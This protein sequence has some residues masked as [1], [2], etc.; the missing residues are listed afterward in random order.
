VPLHV[1]IHSSPFLV[2]SCVPGGFAHEICIGF[3]AN[4]CLTDILPSYVP[5]RMVLAQSRKEQKFPCGLLYCNLI[6][7]TDLNMR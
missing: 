2:D 6:T 5:R 4:M 1:L 3:V 7:T